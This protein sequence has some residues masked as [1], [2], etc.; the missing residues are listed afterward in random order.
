MFHLTTQTYYFSQSLGPYPAQALE[1]MVTSIKQSY[2]RLG[3]FL[4]HL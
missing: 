1:E 3:K 2:E 4:I